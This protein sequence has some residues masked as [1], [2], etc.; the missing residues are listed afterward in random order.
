MYRL[1]LRERPLFLK[2]DTVWVC[3]GSS[4]AWRGLSLTS[5]GIYHD[6]LR[7]IYGCDSVYALVLRNYPSYVYEDTAEICDGDAYPW[8]GRM[9][10]AMGVYTDS[11]TTEHAC[12]SVYR[13][14]LQ[15]HPVHRFF[16]VAPIC[17]SDV[18]TWRG[19]A[20][21]ESGMYYDSLHSRYG[22]DSVYVL[23]LRVY[24]M[25]IQADTADFCHGG[26]YVWRGRVLTAAGDYSDSLKAAFDCD[27]VFSLCLRER[28]LYWRSDTVSVCPGAAYVWHGRSLVTSGVYYDSLQ[29][30]YGCDSVEVIQFRVL[31]AYEMHD[32]L[33]LCAG[34]YG[35][36][37]RFRRLSETGVYYDSLQTVYACDSV[38]VLHV[39]VLPSYEH[40]DTDSY[41]AGSV[42]T[43]RGRTLMS[44]G[45]YYDS[46]KSVSS[47]DSVYT[48]RLYRRPVQLLDTH[49]RHCGPEPYVWRQ[50]ALRSS[51]VYD[52]TLRNA[53]G[54]D[55][56][57]RLHLQLLPSYE[58]KDTQHVCE[59][60][61]YVW[62]GR[63]LTFAGDYA[64]SLYSSR[65]CDSV[66]FLHLMVYPGYHQLF[67]DTICEGEAYNRNG[68]VIPAD[69]TLG[70]DW[71][72][73]TDSLRTLYG[74][75][76]IRSLQLFVRRLPTA[77]G[78]VY[79]DTLIPQTGVYMY[80]VD[81]LPGI[82]GYEW[83][84]AS[85]TLSLS[86]F[87]PKAWVNADTT[88]I[89]YDTLMVRGH[90]ACGVTSWQWLPI[91]F[92]IGLKVA[93]AERT[94]QIRAY[95]NPANAEVFLELLDCTEWERPA[96]RL[97]D[98]Q[99]RCL[100]SGN[101][102]DGKVMIRL[103]GLPRGMYLIRL[104]SGDKA[105]ASLKVVKY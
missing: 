45:L 28:P 49:A 98:M 4:Y 89:M 76:S 10:T 87:G 25:Y 3:P 42:Y 94:A 79:G 96:W 27:S 83:Q 9:L 105:C 7:S 74:C 38:Y 19:R 69:S 17:A 55:S 71:L 5:V 70:A 52:D 64:D 86:S 85:Q 51:G 35:S 40:A 54:C 43:W 97:Y 53:H 33:S 36:W 57:I 92:T 2:T 23:E 62:R 81:T 15:V 63:I 12:D 48:L 99:G 20:L 18:Y 29:S 72:F 103:E 46:L 50:R 13:L 32:T 41:C 30:R 80:Y 59:G 31:P 16:T 73:R 104:F 88:C 68:F 22:C 82:S 93:E 1:C 84:C 60:D 44:P 39:Q 47:C 58:T 91:H 26:T 21:R 95:P 11:L 56:V 37:R 8:R 101:V 66:F 102:D 67:S 34:E 61:P 100:S 90:H 6:S 78:N 65:G 75:D 77:L 14:Y 24:P